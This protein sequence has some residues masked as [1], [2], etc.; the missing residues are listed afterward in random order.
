MEGCPSALRIE[1][2]DKRHTAYVPAKAG[3]SLTAL[4]ADGLVKK[5]TEGPRA[6]QYAI[7]AA[8][9]EALRLHFAFHAATDPYRR[10]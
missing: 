8:G 10:K 9:E 6:G 3:G 7:T 4:R 1:M 2:R 5:L